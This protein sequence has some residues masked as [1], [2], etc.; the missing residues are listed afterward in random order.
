[1]F[2]SFTWTR[3]QDFYVH[4]CLC[5]SCCHSHLSFVSMDPV[6]VAS[7]SPDPYQ[8]QIPVHLKQRHFLRKSTYIVRHNSF[9]MQNI[10]PLMLRWFWNIHANL[11]PC[12]TFHNM[13]DFWGEVIS[14]HSSPMLEDNHL[15]SVCS[16]LFTIFAAI[17]HPQPEDAQLLW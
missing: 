16:C 17:I 5:S 1:M 6:D 15:S 10:I 13:L 12:V 2:T 9:Q 8:Q 3:K 4:L 14:P 11:R 7:G